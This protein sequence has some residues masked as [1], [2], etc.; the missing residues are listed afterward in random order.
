MKILVDS[1]VWMFAP[2]ITLG[3]D[4]YEVRYW[5]MPIWVSGSF[6]GRYKKCF[7]KMTY[8]IKIKKIENDS[9]YLRKCHFWSQNSNF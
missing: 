4:R 7:T 9:K 2:G 1:T 8:E 6:A 3:S 5:H